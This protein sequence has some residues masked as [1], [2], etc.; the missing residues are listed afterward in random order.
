MNTALRRSATTALRLA[1]L[2]ALATLAASSE[3]VFGNAAI[4]RPAALIAAPWLVLLGAGVYILLERHLRTKQRLADCNVQLGIERHARQ[5]AEHAQADIHTSLCRLI[6]QQDHVRENERNRIARDIHDDLGQHLLS[7]KIEL[8][9]I[10]VSSRGAHPLLHQQAGR[11]LRNI[12][13]SIASLRAIINNLRPIALEQGLQSA[14]K[15]H[16]A[17]FS[18]LNGIRHEL[19]AS[20]DAFDGNRDGVVD[21]MLLRV[22][23]ESLAN[24]VRHAEATEVK[25]A[26][27]R[28]GDQLTL[29]I[30]DDGVGMAGW[31]QARG[32]GLIG[33]AD[34]AVAAGGRF[35]IDSEPGAGTVLSLS[36]PLARQASLH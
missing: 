31:P 7:L 14:I 1:V 26:L 3:A 5:L 30:R 22:L 27:K 28:N 6:Q 20:A 12:D 11:L 23:Q 17:E 16:L 32:C 18:R 10:E 8:S 34:R 29:Q 25:V 19:D 21:A 24:V 33:I 15:A 36:I 4:P 35:A 2:A 9:L 13:L